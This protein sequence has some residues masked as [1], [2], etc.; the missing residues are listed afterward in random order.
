MAYSGLVNKKGSAQEYIQ[1][2]KLIKYGLS[3]EQIA[4]VLEKDSRT[5]EAIIK[6]IA[7]HALLK[8]IAYG[9]GKANRRKESKFP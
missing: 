3:S 2:A 6:A 8:L 1:T 7:L 9:T 4:D 5:I